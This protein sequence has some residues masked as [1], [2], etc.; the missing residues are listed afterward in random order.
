MFDLTIL[1]GRSFL[2]EPGAVKASVAKLRTFSTCPTAR[3]LATYRAERLAEARQVASKAVKGGSGKVGL[4]PV[5]GPIEQRM[6]SELMKLG[7]TSCEEIGTMLDVLLADPSVESILLHVDSPG[8]SSYGVEEVSTKIHAARSQKKIYAISDSLE[9]SAAF[10][11]GSSARYSY[12]T[13]GGDIGSHGVYAVHIDQSRAL[14][15]DGVTVNL[16]R[17]GKYKAEAAPFAPLTL[18]A[19]EHLQESVNQTYDK[20]TKALARNRSVSQTKVRD[21]FGQGRLL[22]ADDA[23]K[24]GMVDGIETFESLMDRLTGA[25]KRASAEMEALRKAHAERRKAVAG[26]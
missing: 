16:I 15:M 9:A 6:T 23:L 26:K 5:H 22:S 17:A 1:Q 4:I 24:A 10:W 21:D 20:F 7:G 11:I 8:G 13:P 2:M 19:R 3:E 12:I 18:E 25:G 14:D